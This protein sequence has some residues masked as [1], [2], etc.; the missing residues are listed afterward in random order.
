VSL[1]Q[2]DVEL[3]MADAAERIE[4]TVSDDTNSGNPVV[5]AIQQVKEDIANGRVAQIEINQ[6]STRPIDELDKDFMQ[7][8]ADRWDD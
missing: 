8:A 2:K 1:I 3:L 4:P 7:Y 6:N 5:A